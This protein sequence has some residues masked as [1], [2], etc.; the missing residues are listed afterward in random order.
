MRSFKVWAASA[1]AAGA[2][3][4]G[5][6]AANAELVYGIT[7]DNNLFSFDSATPNNILT[8]V[9][10]TGLQP[11][12]FI[13]TIDFRPATGQLYA[14][15]STNR[16]Y[17]LNTS[18]AAATAVGGVFMPPLNGAAFGMDFN[19]TSD[20]IRLHSD[21]N[22]NLRLNPD[23]GLVAATDPD[24]FYAAGDPGAGLDPNI[25][26]TAYTNNFAGATTTSLYSIDSVRDTLNIHSGA[27]GFASMTTVGTL[28]NAAGT[29]IPFQDYSGMDVS[30]SGTAFVHWNNAAGLFGT[31]D[32]ATGVITTTGNMGGGLFVRDIAVTIPEPASAMMLGVA[33]LLLRRRK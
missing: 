23:T 25:V 32:L 5:A 21:T 15:G 1:V 18:T 6:S 33:G 19:P 20:R 9:Y 10:V 8:G 30:P 31:I 4:A 7:F 11:N 13:Q 28:R 2:L 22:Q 29:T 24:L 3:L 12:E 27:P 17:T 16:V 14:I 26:A